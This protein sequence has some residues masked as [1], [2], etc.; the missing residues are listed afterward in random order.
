M[1]VSC[2]TVFGMRFQGHFELFQ[3]LNEITNQMDGKHEMRTFTKFYPMS[4]TEIALK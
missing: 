2:I 1:T 3:K 4:T